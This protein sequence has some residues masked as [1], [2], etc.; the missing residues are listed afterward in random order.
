MLPGLGLFGAGCGALTGRGLIVR[1][2]R[3]SSRLILQG[4]RTVLEDIGMQTAR[5]LNCFNAQRNPDPQA[6]AAFLAGLRPGE[7]AAGGQALLRGHG[8]PMP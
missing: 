6:L 4:N 2:R 5:F 3:V 7:T 8:S 1:S